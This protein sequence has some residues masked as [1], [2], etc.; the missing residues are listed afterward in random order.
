VAAPGRDKSMLKTAVLLCSVGRAFRQQ[1]DYLRVCIISSGRE[2]ESIRTVVLDGGGAGR[3]VLCGD[4]QRGRHHV[5]VD[6]ATAAE[7][8]NNANYP[9]R[10]SKD[11]FS[12]STS[13]GT[14]RRITLS[15]DPTSR[16]GDWGVGLCVHSAQ[17]VTDA[18]A[19]PNEVWGEP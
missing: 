8:E 15:F 19:F 17:H 9:R 4:H 18:M 1:P 13:R 10:K 14:D 12:F 2:G 11:A 7:Q 5:A 6:P 3:R 16:E